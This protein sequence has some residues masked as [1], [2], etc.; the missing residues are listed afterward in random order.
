MQRRRLLYVPLAVVTV[1]GAPIRVVM[2]IRHSADEVYRLPTLAVVTVVVAAL[3]CLAASVLLLALPRPDLIVL[4]AA[5]TFLLLFGVLSI[6]SIGLLLLLAGAGL[7][8]I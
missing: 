4:P 6:F 5:A 8:A 1:G 3:A 7:V 2:T